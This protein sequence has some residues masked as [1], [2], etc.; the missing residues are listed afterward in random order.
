MTKEGR[1]KTV[2][3]VEIANSADPT[4]ERGYSDEALTANHPWESESWLSHQTPP[5]VSG[6]ALPRPE[7]ELMRPVEAVGTYLVRFIVLLPDRP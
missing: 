2:H 1:S 3:T 5:T 4:A 6:F 7:H